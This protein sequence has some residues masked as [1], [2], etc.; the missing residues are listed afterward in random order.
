MKVRIISMTLLITAC[1][2]FNLSLRIPNQSVVQAQVTASCPTTEVA[3]TTVGRVGSV[4]DQFVLRDPL[5]FTLLSADGDASFFATNDVNFGSNATLQRVAAAGGS[6]KGLRISSPGGKTVAVS[7]REAFWDINFML[8]GLGA[9]AGDRVRMF[10]QPDESGQRAFD[11]ARFTIG[12]GGAMISYLEPTSKLYANGHIQQN[13]GALL[14][15]VIGAGQ[16]GRRTDQITIALSMDSRAPTMACLHLG[17]EIIRAGGPGTTTLAFNTI[18][19][20]RE[21]PSNG[22][23]MGVFTG[24]PGTYPTRQPCDRACPTCAPT[25]VSANVPMTTIGANGDQ[26]LLRDPF[27]L[28]LANATGAV[29][30]FG[31]NDLNFGGN[32]TLT[33][34]AAAGGVAQGLRVAGAGSRANALSCRDKPWDINFMLAGSGATAGDRIRLYLQPSEGSSTVVNVATFVVSA[35]GG[36]VNVTQIEPTA[37]LYGNGHVRQNVGAFLG[38]TT[39][40]GTSGRRTDQ[41]TIALSMDPRA[42]TIGCQ[43]LGVEVIRDGGDGA[44]T[45]VFNSIVVVRNNAT[46]ATGTGLFTGQIGSYPARADCDLAC[47]SCC[48]T[49][50]VPSTVVGRAGGHEDQFLIDPLKFTLLSSGGDGS[51]F[52]TTDANFGSNAT[53]SRIAAAGGS[54][55]GFRLSTPGGRALAASCRDSFWDINFMLAGSGVT[56]GD[57]VTLVMQ[58]DESGRGVFEL[59]RFTIGSTGATLAYLEPTAKLYANG[60]IQQN[61]GAVLPYGFAAGTSGR[62]TDQITIALSMD[63]KAPTMGCLYLL[64]VIRRGNGI[65]TTTLVF[66]TLVLVREGANNGFGPGLFTG[67]TGNYPTRQACDRLCPACPF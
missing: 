2:L 67:Q 62:R 12:A 38:F 18:V 54:A 42:P 8:A 48:P 56:T 23:G 30:F 3:S 37:A 43:H 58:P 20:T 36:G 59:A 64:P 44:L 57:E 63:P 32:A 17:V 35:G 49:T 28:T 26:F 24:Q 40:A 25:C 60:H 15:Y 66:N 31:T 16:S 47:P 14:P 61:V 65:G 6:G 19:L 50:E 13:V 5:T 29:S 39:P 4:E 46:T 22:T 10:M 9:T 34:I 21:G 51:F 33:R 45:V 27:K 52:A 55:K 7:C 1:L 11:L 41:I 53:L